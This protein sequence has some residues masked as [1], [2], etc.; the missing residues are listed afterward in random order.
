MGDTGEKSFS[1][2]FSTLYTHTYIHKY[3]QRGRGNERKKALLPELENLVYASGEILFL[4]E[5][6]DSGL[7]SDQP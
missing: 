5:E 1:P 4:S 2:I 6:M 3:T 7:T